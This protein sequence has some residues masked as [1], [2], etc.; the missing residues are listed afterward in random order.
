M[1]K[2]WIVLIATALTIGCSGGGAPEEATEPA[3]APR[4]LIHVQAPEPLELPELLPVSSPTDWEA[5][6][7]NKDREIIEV[8]NILNP[9]AAYITEGFKQYGT[10]FSDTLHDEWLDTQKQLTEGLALYEKAKQRRAG[11]TY[12][13]QLF[14]DM[15]QCWQILVKTGVSGVRAKTMVDDELRRMTGQ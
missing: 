11:G 8:L 3:P 15:E 6:V 12:D 5:R 4:A 13:K 10:R 9:V 7:H 14:L 2:F 1:K